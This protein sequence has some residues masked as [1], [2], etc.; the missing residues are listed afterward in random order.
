VKALLPR[1]IQIIKQINDR[2][3]TLVD[4]TW[5]GDKQV[6]ATLSVVQDRQ[7]RLANMFVVSGFAVNGVAALHSD[8]LV[9]DL[10]PEYHQLWPNK[11]HTVPNGTTPPP[12]IQHSNP[13]LAAFL[14]HTL[15]QVLPHDLHQF[16]NSK[17]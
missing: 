11:F 1:H 14:V 8:L 17:K 3:K 5:P 9:N 10:F 7:V 2:F 6:W 4:N 13:P 12:G 16:I 15:K